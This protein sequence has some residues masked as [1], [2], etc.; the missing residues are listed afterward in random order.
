MSK[1]IVS[2]SCHCVQLNKV[3][4]VGYFSIHPFLK[5]RKRYNGSHYMKD[6]TIANYMLWQCL[7]ARQQH[8]QVKDTQLQEWYEEMEIKNTSTTFKNVSIFRVIQ[9]LWHFPFIPMLLIPLRSYFLLNLHEFHWKPH[10]EKV[11][12]KIIHAYSEK[13]SKMSTQYHGLKIEAGLLHV[14]YSCWNPC[15]NLIIRLPHRLY[16]TKHGDSKNMHVKVQGP[17]WRY[18]NWQLPSKHWGKKAK[19]VVQDVPGLLQEAEKCFRPFVL[20]SHTCIK[21]E[22]LKSSCGDLVPEIFG[23]RSDNIRLYTLFRTC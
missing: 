5:N 16:T 3:V 15:H 10:H 6:T 17:D 13:S 4:K 1:V 22:A 18:R 23:E 21:P 8:W 19:S 12:G 7:S 14:F 9:T 2:S 11:A 20:K